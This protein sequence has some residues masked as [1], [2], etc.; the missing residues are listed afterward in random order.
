MK[1]LE[2]YRAPESYTL[3]TAGKW[4]V[5]VIIAAIVFLVWVW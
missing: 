3:T 5:A 1:W 4:V 2:R